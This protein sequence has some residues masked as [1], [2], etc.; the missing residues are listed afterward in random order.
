MAIKIP[1][2]KLFTEADAKTR[3]FF[4]LAALLGVGIVI[5]L[6]V[7]YLSG[8]AAPTTGPSKVANAPKGLQSVPGGELSPEYYRALVQANAQAAQQAKISGG[9]A[10]ATLMNVPGQETVS[11]TSTN[12]TVMCPGDESANVADDINAL[13]KSGKLSQKDGDML[14]DLAKKNV[15]VE[16]YA[17]AL[18]ELVRQG[19]LTPEQARALLEKYKK[20]HANV[21]LA[22][23]GAAMDAMIKS[24]QLPLT[25]ANQL[26]DLQKKHVTP[27]EYAAALDELV[28]QGKLTPA[29]AA[30]LLAQYT[31]QYAREEAK[32]AAFA[33]AQMAKSGEISADAANS[34]QKL[35][36][37]NASVDEYEAELNRLV[38]EGKMTPAAARKLLEAY[39]ASRNAVQIVS[40]CLGDDAMGKG[41]EVGAFVNHLV[42]MQA[43]NAI[44][45]D[46]SA[47]LKRGVVAGFITP[48]QATCLVS[49]YQAL[50]IPFSSGAAPTV[51]TNIPGT[52]DFAKLAQKVQQQ[53][54]GQAS[55]PSTVQTEEF[56]AAAVQARALAD[57]DRMK[58][59]QA[60]QAAMNGQAASLIDSW[61]VV[62]M[63]HM[64]GTPPE[65]P[66]TTG[67]GGGAGGAS[68]TG[69]A[70]TKAKGPSIIKAGTI[71]FAILE[72]AVDSD[73]PDTPV[74]ATIIQDGPFKG[75]KVMGKLNLVQG[76]DKISLNFTLMDMDKWDASKTI[77]AFAIDPETAR[78]VLATDV[79]HH[80]MLR[81]G[82]IMATSFLSGYSSS[83]TQAGTSTTGIF[84]TSSTH[85]DLS[86]GNKIAVAIGQIGTNLN[87]TVQQ[88]INT[89]TTVKVSSGVGIGL[90]F[91]AP[92][93]D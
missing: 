8:E 40:G 2:M 89:P 25:V 26:L 9:S 18:D 80:Y 67:E 56:T 33:L 51:E 91:T 13:I 93:T 37:K 49:R 64:A 88:F 35:Q 42:S 10:V 54:P 47:E 24:G 87:S 71:L 30:A 82:S 45:T 38:A 22:E 65:K 72:T 61:K 15:S 19:K 81:Y 7:S 78:T 3:V 11:T 21:L 20:Q 34:L 41:G 52:S 28:R 46:Y 29:Q 90:L 77:S 6:T 58:R 62:K 63:T 17:A 83:I 53:K 12:C 39:R 85:P 50:V 74:M 36:D 84:G 4:L 43:N 55:A 92:V 68:G 70:E 59:I 57:Q 32:K 79:D 66:K 86:P 44:I 31:Q 69:S 48:E 75:A 27:A 1:G 60:I 16:E 5:Y 14:L 73:Y 23:S 76:K